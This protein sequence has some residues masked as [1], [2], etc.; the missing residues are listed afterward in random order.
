MDQ[1][2]RLDPRHETIVSAVHGNAAVSDRLKPVVINHFAK[3]VV[4]Q[5]VRD[6]FSQANTALVE[7][8]VHF[9]L[10]PLRSPQDESPQ[11][12]PGGSIIE[13]ISLEIRVAP[14]SGDIET[15]GD[16][17]MLPLHRQTKVTRAG[18]YIGRELVAS[19]GREESSGDLPSDH[20]VVLH[21]YS[22]LYGD[23]ENRAYR[24]SNNSGGLSVTL[25]VEF[26]GANPAILVSSVAIIHTLRAGGFCGV[27]FCGF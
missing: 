1:V 8:L 27:S 25:T 2:Q 18:L 5:P 21:L 15:D 10:P 26:R 14:H 6:I 7:G 13:S 9:A 4:L 3:G 20:D 12:S 19:W 11:G 16:T 22:G 23:E 24:L 17:D